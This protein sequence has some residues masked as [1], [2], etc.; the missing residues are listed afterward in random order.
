MPYLDLAGGILTSPR[1]FPSDLEESFLRF[2]LQRA[3][4]SLVADASDLILPLDSL[5]LKIAFPHNTIAVSKQRACQMVTG[6]SSLQRIFYFL[7]F[8]FVTTFTL[9]EILMQLCLGFPPPVFLLFVPCGREKT[10][11]GACLSKM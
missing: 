10:Q 6:C 5:F 4:S 11:Q 3:A 2:F 7:F 1:E 8:R 9:D